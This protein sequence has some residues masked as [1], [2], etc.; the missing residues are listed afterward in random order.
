MFSFYELSLHILLLLLSAIFRKT[1]GL[2]R[3]RSALAYWG[4]RISSVCILVSDGAL[5]SDITPPSS[6][7]T[8]CRTS[9]MRE[10]E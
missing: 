10:G 5:V 7:P 8:G 3:E 4:D 6:L 1:Q 9:A 2:D